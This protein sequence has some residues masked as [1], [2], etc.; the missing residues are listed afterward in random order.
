[1]TPFLVDWT[2]AALDM[3]AE[4]WMQTMNRAA[5]NAAQNQIDA[6]LASNPIGH[7]KHLGEGLYKLIVPPLTVF[8][9]VDQAKKTVEVSAVWYTP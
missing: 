6:L 3:L 5:V 7:G 8:F 2:D 9:S 1:M 4:I